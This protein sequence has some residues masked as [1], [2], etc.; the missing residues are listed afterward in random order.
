MHAVGATPST[1]LARPLDWRELPLSLSLSL[2]CS[3]LMVSL[4]SL[5]YLFSF[6]SFE[7]V[8]S[9]LF[10]LLH[11]C[12]L[13][14]TC[15]VFSTFQALYGRSNAAAQAISWR[16]GITRFLAFVTCRLQ[17]FQLGGTSEYRSTPFLS[18]PNPLVIW[19]RK[20]QNAR[21]Y[22]VHKQKWIFQNYKLRGDEYFFDY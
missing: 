1:C 14:L 18:S 10:L 5:Y 2:L 16:D 3:L 13:D 12:S 17:T 11:S 15:L 4:V 7:Q 19:M 21:S 22:F 9:L 20:T 6:S 8:C